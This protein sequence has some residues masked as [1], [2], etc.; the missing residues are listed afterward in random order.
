MSVDL[1]GKNQNETPE[2]LFKLYRKTRDQE[3]KKKLMTLYIDFVRS[4]VRKMNLTYSG[5][6]LGEDDL[7]DIGM[8]GLSN[9]I[10]KFDPKVG[11]KF[12]T[13]AYPRIRGNIIDEIRKIDNLPRSVRDKI[14]QIDKARA[15]VENKV[16]DLADHGLIASEAGLSIEKYNQVTTLGYISKSISFNLK[17]GENVE[18]GDFIKSEDK[19]PEE[20][21]I[22]NEIKQAIADEIKK[23]TEKERLVIVLYYYEELTFKEIGEILHLSESRVSQLHSGALKKIRDSLKS[24]F[25]F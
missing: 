3:V 20:N 8:I 19:D 25:S 4:I 1:I 11:V 6:L 14:D 16:G 24:K 18:L 23:L 12:E 17:I 21:L 15:K 5:A 9:A 7:V 10:D 22:E 2:K 13:F